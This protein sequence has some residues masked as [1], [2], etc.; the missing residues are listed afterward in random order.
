MIPGENVLLIAEARIE[1]DRASRYLVQF[2]HHASEMSQ[3]LRTDGPGARHQPH[4][5]GPRAAG[6][7]PQPEGQAGEQHQPQLG[8]V[9]WSD[10]TGTMSLNWGRCTLSAGPDALVLRAEATDQ[11]NL[12]RLQDLM[13]VRLES[14]GRRDGLR[15]RW[16]PSRTQ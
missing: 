13:T 10:S 3:R 2:C 9:E 11:D 12:R 4:D 16:Q 15:V 14:F 7:E 5:S 8:K 1:T 6:Q